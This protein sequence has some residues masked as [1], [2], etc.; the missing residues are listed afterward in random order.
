MTF[1][2]I[3]VGPFVACGLETTGAAWCWGHGF[4]GNGSSQIS[5]TNP[6]PV[7]G[8]HRFTSMAL[9]GI[10]CGLTTTGEAWCWGSVGPGESLGDGTL[11]TSSVPV[12]VAGGHR[13][14]ALSA[15]PCGLK[16]N[17]EVWCWGA[18]SD[19]TSVARTSPVKL[20]TALAFTA[21]SNGCALAADQTA[22]CWGLRGLTGDGFLNGPLYYPTPV[23]VFGG[24]RFTE[25]SVGGGHT[26]ARAV[27]GTWCWGFQDH[28][29][30]GF[31]DPVFIT[32]Q[33]PTKVAFP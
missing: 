12:A 17:G 30:L 8:S 28:G 5:Y 10:S 6:V 7:A 29:Q 15:G 9:G 19:G 16:S 18:S 1:S 20:A 11:L 13:F 3:Y 21:L 23:Q 25:I 31:G 4:L 26:C 22:W 2:S 24:R 32:N 14:T 33:P 27:D